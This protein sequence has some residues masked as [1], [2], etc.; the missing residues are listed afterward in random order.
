MIKVLIVDDSAVVRKVLSDEFSKARDIHVVGTAVDPFVARDKIVQLRP[1]VITL[2]LEMPRMDGLTFLGKFMRYFPLPVVVVSS[3]TPREVRRPFER[4]KWGPWT[5]SESPARPTPSP[6]S[7]AC[8]SIR[9][10]PH[11]SPAPSSLSRRPD[12]PDRRSIP[13]TPGR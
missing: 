2:Y 5:S 12:R 6:A 9:F 3:L 7:P 10:A 11:R 13:R 8:S 1:D 4:W